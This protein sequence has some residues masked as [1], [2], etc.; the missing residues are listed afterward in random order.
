M[1]C[2]MF[3]VGLATSQISYQPKEQEKQE[4]AIYTAYQETGIVP[5]N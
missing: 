5:K 3:N 4:E 1:H 2:P